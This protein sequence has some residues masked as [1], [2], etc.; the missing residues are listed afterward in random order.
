VRHEVRPE[1]LTGAARWMTTIARQWDDRLA[2]IAALAEAPVP[3]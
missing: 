2:A 3:P 1:A